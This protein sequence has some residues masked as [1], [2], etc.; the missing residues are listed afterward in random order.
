MSLPSH[1]QLLSSRRNY[2]DVRAALLRDYPGLDDETLADTL[3]G[4]TELPD[5]LCALIRSMLEDQSLLAG[6]AQRL[7]DMRTRHARLATRIEKKRA[8]ALACMRDASITALTQPDYSAFVRKA[9][10]TLEIRAEAQIPPQFWKAQE[11]TLDR[12]ALLGALKRGED[13]PGATLSPTG[14]QLS[15]RTR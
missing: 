2:D 12:T 1:T 3:E 10:P 5:L 11:P 15:V 7:T 14:L 4:L 6:L 13:I 9:S 8:L